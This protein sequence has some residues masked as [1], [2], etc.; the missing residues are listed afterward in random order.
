MALQDVLFATIWFPYCAEDPGHAVIDAAL[1][2]IQGRAGSCS[3]VATSK[4]VK[5]GSGG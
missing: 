3:S 5:L 2:Q 4:R 1:P